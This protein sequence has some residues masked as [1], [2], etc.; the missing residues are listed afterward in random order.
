[1]VFPPLAISG[2]EL[3]LLMAGLEQAI[4]VVVN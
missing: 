4:E 3:D 1:V 2:Q